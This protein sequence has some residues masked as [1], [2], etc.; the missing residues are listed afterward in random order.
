MPDATSLLA[1]VKGRAA[2]GPCRRAILAAL[3]LIWKLARRLPLVDRARTTVR[4]DGHRMRVRPFSYDDLLSVSPDYELILRRWPPDEGDVVVDAGAFIGRHTLDFA[5]RVGPRGQVIAVEPLAE[6][7]RLLAVNVALNR[8]DNV[9]CLPIA[10]GESDDAVKL[11]YARESSTATAD[12]RRAVSAGMT[13]TTH[14]RQRRLDD[15]LRELGLHAV[16]YLKID[17]EGAEVDVLRGA[18]RLLRQGSPRVIVELHGQAAAES[19]IERCLRGW[20]YDCQI[21]CEAGRRFCVAQR[22][23]ALTCKMSQGL[24]N[25]S[26]GFSTHPAAT[27]PP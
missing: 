20:G 21:V 10:L 15:V 11:H 16:D 5:S 8:L 9:I 23:P 19:P 24:R 22:Q 25:E 1:S 2:R 3:L 13:K 7:F 14:V 17:V 6:N 27:N 26:A 18:R 12:P 4:V